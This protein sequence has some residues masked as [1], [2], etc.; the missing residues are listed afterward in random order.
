MKRG[1][2][3]STIARRFGISKGAIEQ[4]NNLGRRNRLSVGKQLVIPVPRDNGEDQPPAIAVV[5]REFPQSQTIDRRELGRERI[6]KALSRHRGPRAVADAYD[7]PVVPRNR[8]KLV[9]RIK[10]GDTIGELA[11]FFGVRAT[12]I[13]NWNDVSYRENIIAGTHLTIW[14]KKGNLKRF[15]GINDMSTQDRQSLAQ[16]AKPFP[17]PEEAQ[18]GAA[19]YIV[20]RGDTLGKLAQLHRVTVRQMKVWNRLR[21]NKIVPGQELFIHT[22]DAALKQDDP[23]IATPLVK[24]QTGSGQSLVYVVKKGDTLWDIART[25]DVTIEQLKSWNKLSGKKIRVGQELVIFKDRLA[26]RS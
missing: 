24:Q 4:A 19:R 16:R 22:E 9:Y 20:K 12:D 7:R 5:Q 10:K 25:Y 6:A 11:E 8:E 26:A 3:V 13:R 1:E 14:V 21:S 23:H 15:E 2:T 17:T 18:D